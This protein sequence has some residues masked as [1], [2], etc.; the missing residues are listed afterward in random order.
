MKKNL[1]KMTMLMMTIIFFSSLWGIILAEEFQPL[2]DLK[3]S[4]GVGMTR[5]MYSER[6]VIDYLIWFIWKMSSCPMCMSYHICWIAF[7]VILANP[8]GLIFG[9]ASYF[10]TFFLKKWM[11]ISI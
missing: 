6:L 9:V 5:R 8:I 3:E 11:V 1:L 10:L 2:Q 4:L 7:L